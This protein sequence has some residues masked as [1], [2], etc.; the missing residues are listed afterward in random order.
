M[1]SKWKTLSSKIDYQNKWMLV[2]K[3]IIQNDS[4]EK[5]EFFYISLNTFSIV[6][7]VNNNGQI[8]LSKNYRYIV[9]TNQLELTAGIIEE[10]ET[11]EEA[12]VRELEEETGIV[13]KNTEMLGEIYTTN[14]VS[15]QK[16]YVVLA[17]NLSQSNPKPTEFEQISPVAFYS[18][19]E[20]KNIISKK[21]IT[22][23]PALAAL[24]MYISKYDL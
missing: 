3:N 24:M 12:A 9:K 10:G 14:G 16:G 6:L 22:D 15:D 18:V 23:G 20:I 19:K 1:K 13:A 17:T 8:A 4:R 11:P 5:L 21:L 2:H 7:A